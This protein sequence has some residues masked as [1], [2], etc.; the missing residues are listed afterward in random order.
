M[1]R[2]SDVHEASSDVAEGPNPEVQDG[3]L[4]GPFSAVIP[5]ANPA[6]GMDQMA[7]S[8]ITSLRR[9]NGSVQGGL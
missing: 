4:T 2:I 1:L 3:F 6:S 5:W 7:S 8:S 9:K